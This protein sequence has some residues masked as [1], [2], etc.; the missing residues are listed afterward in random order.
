MKHYF[1]ILLF[2]CKC[3]SAF[4]GDLSQIYDGIWYTFRDQPRAVLR[5][6]WKNFEQKKNF[7]WEVPIQL[8]LG[9]QSDVSQVAIFQIFYRKTYIYP[10]LI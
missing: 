7:Y 9:I 6:S 8:F 5:E 1:P 4:I 10:Y 2:L 3:Y